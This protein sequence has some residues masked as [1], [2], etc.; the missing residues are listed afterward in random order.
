MVVMTYCPECGQFFELANPKEGQRV[1]CPN[2]QARLEVLNLE[3]LE[4]DWAYNEPQLV[5]VWKELE[6]C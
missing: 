1:G 2:C 6:R 4:L 5:E 3:P